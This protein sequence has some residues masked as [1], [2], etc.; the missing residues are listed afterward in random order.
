MTFPR[1]VPV[2][3]FSALVVA[4]V[5][6]VLLL[7][8]SASAQAPA[9]IDE[10]LAKRVAAEKEAR[11]ACKVEICKAFATPKADGGPITCSVTK[12][13]LQSEIQQSILRD[14]LS[15]PWGHAQCTAKID[16]SGSDIAKLMGDGSAE[17][18]LKK[19]AVAC[20][21]DRKAPE[22]GEAYAVTL[23]IEPKI[24]FEKGKATKVV[25]G[26]KDIE[27]P[28]LAKAAIWSATATDNTFNV[29][30][31]AI[32]GEVNEFLFTKCKAD[33]VEVAERK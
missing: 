31:G 32:V 2:V 7:P 13:W 21:L 26:W 18:Q 20:S 33:G 5:A 1:N 15:W 22:T 6:G 16:L 25:M 24:T 28:V 10:A 29:L 23:A 3:C 14:K 27:A 12:T 19:H 17:V 11:R 8:L 9:A 30:S 4:L